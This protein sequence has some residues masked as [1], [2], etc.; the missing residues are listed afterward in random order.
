VNEVVRLRPDERRRARGPL[1][2]EEIDACLVVAEDVNPDLH[3]GL[4]ALRE[5]DPDE[6]RRRLATSERLRFLAELRA[7]EPHL[8]ELKMIELRTDR[9]VERLSDQL[10]AAAARGDARAIDALRPQLVTQMRMQQAFILLAR[11]QA[12][13]RMR[14]KLESFDR[15]Y[16]QDLATV[17]ERI[18]ARVDAIIAAAGAESAEPRGEG[19]DDRAAGGASPAR[20][21]GRRR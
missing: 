17:D 14:E 9:E 1:T 18:R 13:D 15:R 2:E 20:E 10:R 6:F 19:P 5:A 4:L 16:Q 3:R 12:L 8:Y 7:D 21:S 11:K